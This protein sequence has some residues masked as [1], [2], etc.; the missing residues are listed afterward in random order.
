MSPTKSSGITRV[1]MSVTIHGLFNYLFK[2]QKHIHPSPLIQLNDTENTFYKGIKCENF[3]FIVEP[4]NQSTENHRVSSS[5]HLRVTWR[6]DSN[7]T[8]CNLSL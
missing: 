5:L 1:L 3:R 8:F 6:A 4:W 2:L 7:T